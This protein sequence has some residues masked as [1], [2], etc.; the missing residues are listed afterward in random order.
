MPSPQSLFG[1]ACVAVAVGALLV[2]A[3]AATVEWMQPKSV[4]RLRD[5]VRTILGVL[6]GETHLDPDVA[7]LLRRLDPDNIIGSHS[8]TATTGK[9]YIRVCVRDDPAYTADENHHVRLFAVLHEVAHV[10]TPEYGHTDNFWQNFRLLLAVA[11]DRGL[12][13]RAETARIARGDPPYD[14]CGVAVTPSY[15][16]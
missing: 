11:D 5:D 1:A 4:H 12:L 14:L 7:V 16:P 3:Y 13:S 8:S 9:R 2:V 6:V 10:M 15:V